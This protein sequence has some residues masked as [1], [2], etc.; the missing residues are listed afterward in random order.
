MTVPSRFS[1]LEERRS[2]TNWTAL[3]VTRVLKHLCVSLRPLRLC[4][5]LTQN[6]PEP[7]RRRGRREGAEEDQSREIMTASVGDFNSYVMP[8]QMIRLENPAT[9]AL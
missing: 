3:L 1:R 9:I 5:D 8:R 4:G 7:Q 6:Q 2:W